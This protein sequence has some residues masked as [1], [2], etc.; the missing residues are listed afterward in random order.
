VS[1]D[2]GPNPFRC[3]DVW[4]RD[5]KFKEF[6]SSSWYS[7]EVMG[8]GIF[9]FKE[10]LKRLKAYQKIWNKEV[11]GYLNLASKEAQKKIDALDE[12]D[13]GC[14]LTGYER[15]ERKVLLAELN[16]AKFKQEA[17]MFQKTRQ[18][19]IKQG[20]L[21]TRFF[22]SSV[23]WRRAKNQLHGLHVN[24]K[25]CEDKEVIKDKIQSFFEDRFARNDACQVGLDNVNFC[26]I[27]ETDNDML[28]ADFYEE[29]IRIAVWRCDSCKSP[30]PNSFN[31]GFIKFYWDIVKNDVV[32]AVKDFAVN[33]HWPKGTNASFLCLIPKIEN[34]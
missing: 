15:E 25:W 5:S 27:S 24:G 3:L 12:R 4:L 18:S 10:N 17:V 33:G 7:Y 16:K 23:K 8:D 20:D 11:F 26:S 30:D 13:E 22:H 2:W 31:F 34:P 9:I 21:N 14:G 29:E 32:A 19:W 1:V 6:V 28:I